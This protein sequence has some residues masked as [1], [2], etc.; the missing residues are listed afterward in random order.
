MEE[1]V[2]PANVLIVNP[3]KHMHLYISH[4]TNY[5]QFML[6]CRVHSPHKTDLGWD[7]VLL[8]ANMGDQKMLHLFSFFS[9]T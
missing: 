4:G 1:A 2:A 3:Y 7:K 5:D 9:Y 6:M 8:E